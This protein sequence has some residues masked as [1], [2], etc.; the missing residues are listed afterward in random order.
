MSLL[1]SVNDGSPGDSYFVTQSQLTALLG[2]SG[3]TGPAGPQG[4]AGPVGPQGEPGLPAWGDWYYSVTVPPAP[5][6]LTISGGSLLFNYVGQYGDALPFLRSIQ[7]LLVTTG[8]VTITFNQQNGVFGPAGVSFTINAIAF[9]DLTGV[10]TA[11]LMGPVPV[12]PG[13]A[14]GQPVTVFSYI[15]GGIGETGPTGAVGPAGPAGGPTG[16]AGAVGDTGPTG[17]QGPAGAAGGNDWYNYVAMGP[18]NIGNQNI[19]NVGS[20]TAFTGV[21]SNLSAGNLS[22]VNNVQGSNVYANYG[23]FVNLDVYQNF[24]TGYGNIQL[25]SPNPASANPGTLFINGTAQ[26]SRGFTNTY[27]NA[28]GLEVEGTSLIPANTS[29]KFSALP[30]GGFATQ[31]F[32]LN[33]ILA[34]A[35]ML[36]VVPGYMSLNAGAAANIAT[37]GPQA[38]AAGSYINLESAQGQVYISGTASDI[39]DI[40]FENGGQVLNAGGMTMQGNGGGH[41]AQINNIGGYVDPATSKGM[42]IQNCESIYG[43]PSSGTGSSIYISSIFGD[44]TLYQSTLSSY[45]NGG[46][47]VYFSTTTSTIVSTIFDSTYTTLFSLG[48]KGLSLYNVST[49]S[50]LNSVTGVAGDMRATGDVIALQGGTTA[51]LSTTAKLARFKDTTEFWVSAQGTTAALGATG[52]FLNPFST[53]Q[54]AINAAEA[55]SSAANICVINLASGHYTENLTF[56]KGYVILAGAMNTQTMNEV[57]EITGSVTITATGAAD[58]ANR[59]IGFMGLNITCGAGQLFTNNSTTQTNTWFQDCKIF[60][61]SQ[62]YVHTAGAAPDARTYFSNCD[63]SQTAAANTSP[64]I[65]IGIGAIEIERVDFTTDGNCNSLLLSGTAVLFRMSLTTFEHTTN[66]TT[67]AP[68]FQI[69]SSSTSPQPIGQCTFIY[70]NAAS[71][72]ASPTSCGIYIASGVATALIVLNCYFTMTGCTGSA[73]NIIAYNGVGSP[74]IIANEIQSLYIPVTAPFAYTIASGIT[75]VPYTNSVGLSAGSYSSSAT[76]N[77]AVAGTP[78]VITMNTTEYQFGTQL[79]AS[80][81]IYAGRTGVFKFTYSIQLNNTSGGNETVDIFIKKNGAT[82]VRSGS[83]LLVGNNAPQFPFCEFVLSMNATDYLEVFFNGT[84]TNVQAI[85]YAATASV[86]AIPS[87]IANLVQ[88]STRP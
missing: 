50:G 79:I 9:N 70:T 1:T 34:P 42:G 88:I 67:A 36:S 56:T 54:E 40:I 74:S 2:A 19:S 4:I 47:T 84:S 53:V 44:T 41:L 17:I 82:V 80:T 76:Q 20:I 26:V 60:V 37:G 52:S 32:E 63:I 65:Q 72:A 77:I 21:F 75:V 83:K 55:I 48:G 71:K 35:S 3:I 25:G 85:A 23:N 6:N 16:P 14:V 5:E 58:L 15:N 66:S 43:V 45:T 11:T 73:N 78:Q 61:N 10:A 57:T 64:V 18:I 13:F 33:T 51:S 12:L 68:M 69:T 24:A 46:S 7:R 62:F 87:I 38:F 86:P 81:R 28:L 31:R 8:E 27:A 22:N 49:I 59:Q 29:F 30:V 39:C